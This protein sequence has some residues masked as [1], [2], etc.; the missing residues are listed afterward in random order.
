MKNEQ[1][2]CVLQ[3]GQEEQSAQLERLV[4]RGQCGR[5]VQHGWFSQ[6]A[7][8]EQC[9]PLE[10]GEIGWIHGWIRCGCVW[11]QGE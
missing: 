11:T 9:G 2:W 7:L 4:Q 10:M 3:L 5:L 6:L 1:E 8:G